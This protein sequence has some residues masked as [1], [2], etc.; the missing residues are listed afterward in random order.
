MDGQ[1]YSCVAKHY[2]Q[3]VIFFVG[4]KRLKIN[5]AKKEHHQHDEVGAD[6]GVTGK[7]RSS[8]TP[9]RLG[10]SVDCSGE[11]L[12][13]ADMQ[14]EQPDLA[15]ACAHFYFPVRPAFLLSRSWAQ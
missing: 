8:R 3:A 13:R 11:K 2:S 6:Y 7:V 12:E 5:F 4:I 15:Q 1:M 14:C 10:W 9:Y